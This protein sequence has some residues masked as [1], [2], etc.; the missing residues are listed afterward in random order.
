MGP[1]PATWPAGALRWSLQQA[2]EQFVPFGSGIEGLMGLEQ[3]VLAGKA[4]R[5][6]VFCIFAT[7]VP[8]FLAVNLP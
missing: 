1:G 2:R 3:K 5:N 6:Y 7:T 8:A 4:G